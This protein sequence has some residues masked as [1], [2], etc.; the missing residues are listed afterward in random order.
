MCAGESF[1]RDIGVGAIASRGGRMAAPAGQIAAVDGP[2]TPRNCAARESAMLQSQ[3][4]LAS[5]HAMQTTR[6]F[7]NG[8]SQAVRLPKEFR[9]DGNEVFIRKD[10]ATGDVVLSARPSSASSLTISVGIPFRAASHTLRRSTTP[11]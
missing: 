11:Y 5:E 7:T 2:G 4:L 9:F 8:N 10:A 3:A 1:A 6:V